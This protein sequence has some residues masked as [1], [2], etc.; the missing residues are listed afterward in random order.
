M[1]RANLLKITLLMLLGCS[2]AC[3]PVV[4]LTRWTSSCTDGRT[5]S[6]GIQ[7]AIAGITQLDSISTNHYADGRDVSFNTHSIP[8]QSTGIN[9]PLGVGSALVLKTQQLLA[10]PEGL[11]T[12]N[13]PGWIVED[14]FNNYSASH[15]TFDI[16]KR[17][18]FATGDFEG[19]GQDQM[20]VLY[21]NGTA[22]MYADMLND[23][24]VAWRH[25]FVNMQTGSIY[26]FFLA[27]GDFD[28]NGTDELAVLV[29]K[30]SNFESWETFDVKNNI[31]LPLSGEFTGSGGHPSAIVAGDFD[32][33]HRDELLVVLGSFEQYWLYDDALALDTLGH[34]A[35]YMLIDNGSK[36]LGGT[37]IG[38]ELPTVVGDIDGDGRDEVAVTLGSIT[39]GQNGIYILDL[40][41]GTLHCS[42]APDVSLPTSISPYDIHG[43]DVDGDGLIELIVNER[44]GVGGPSP[45]DHLIVFDDFLNSYAPLFDIPEGDT[46]G[47]YLPTGVA[48][49]I[50]CDGLDEVVAAWHSG[51]TIYGNANQSFSTLYTNASMGIDANFIKIKSVAFS[52]TG[53]KL[54]YT[55]EHS[56]VTL[57]PGI[58]VAL[59]A[60][61]YYTGVGT[62]LAGCYTGYGVTSSSGSSEATSIGTK[63]SW[64]ISVE[65]NFNLGEATGLHG[66]FGA[67][68]AHDCEDVFTTTNTQTETTSY[69]N[70]YA[71]GIYDNGILFQISKYDQYK[72]TVVEHPNATWVGTTMSFQIPQT[73]LLFKTTMSYF[74][75]AYPSAP[76]I[77][78]EAFT[79]VVGQPWTYIN[80]TRAIVMPQKWASGTQTVGLGTAS[81][82]VEI[83]VEHENSTEVSNAWSSQYSI[84]GSVEAGYG[85]FSVTVEG[86]YGWGR[87]GDRSFETKI[88]ESIIFEGSV[89]D[90]ANAGDYSLLNFTF[91]LLVYNLNYGNVSCLVLNY[92]VDGATPISGFTPEIISESVVSVLVF[93]ITIAMPVGIVSHLI[94]AGKK[95]RKAVPR[96]Q[97][98]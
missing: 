32:G 18:Q 64:G 57:P 72:Y 56:V 39:P 89:G 95:G 23:S 66:G 34:A 81:N 80:S 70:K 38:Y 50:N 59:A 96:G 91:G 9:P 8:P 52:G 16:S 83:E 3:V 24:H 63:S 77:G 78:N 33:D 92:W 93:S 84:G 41:A 73:P 74:Y 71:S 45:Q 53:V 31:S 55:G 54:Q 15:T 17:Y 11:F 37:A 1:K 76:G 30:S 46:I 49:D 60:P 79:H 94:R 68:F 36:S 44:E 82:S 25:Q 35:P 48:V 12:L 61:P 42:I 90:I 65:A 22:F 6:A 51:L 58:M 10:L 13:Q 19:S 14:T 7:A 27:A 47:T 98:S 43:G 97:S 29:L 26:S 2:A 86:H 5:T 75:Q 21:E 28:G 62:N 67:K 69:S 85:F 88:G 40:A 4:F 87:T 20:I